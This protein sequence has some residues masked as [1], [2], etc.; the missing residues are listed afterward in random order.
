MTDTLQKFD[1]QTQEKTLEIKNFRSIKNGS[2]ELAPFTILYGPNGAGK[3]SVIYS[4]LTM[5]NL[6]LSPGQPTDKFFDYFFTNLGK[7]SSVI[8][9]HNER[10]DIEFALS[11]SNDQTTISYQITLGKDKGKYS[12]T[13]ALIDGIEIPVT[14][15]Y[16]LDGEVQVKIIDNNGF[17]EFEETAVFSWNGIVG[18]SQIVGSIDNTNSNFIDG[19]TNYINSPAEFIRRISVVPLK[20]GFTKP[21]YSTVPLTPNLI[22]EDELA[23]FLSAEKHL[24]SKISTY[25]EAILNRDLRVNFIP[26]TSQFTIDVT[27]KDA[28]MGIGIVNDGFG[29]SQVVYLL[30]KSAAS[31]TDVICIE[32][33]EIHLHPSAIRNLAKILVEIQQSEGKQF[34]ISTHS[35][36]L[37]ASMLALVSK[38]TL[39]SEAIKCYF[40]NKEK[41]ETFFE[42]Q[43]VNDKGQIEGGLT[44]FIQSELEE[45]DEYLKSR[46]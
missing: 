16:N 3:S 28:R 45:I 9:D 37:L 19:F 41:R 5:R 14:F 34:V 23:T 22:S 20:R 44:S 6:V 24:V 42:D 33:P 43:K 39:S 18:K 30:A 21:T 25:L 12:L 7:Y 26:G 2:I 1:V 40:V 46:Q 13:S 15:P 36:A 35:E 10:N 31:N 32:E 11:F 27:D 38:G 8:F 4:L 17:S 29:V